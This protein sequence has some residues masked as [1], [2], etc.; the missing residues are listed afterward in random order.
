M[1]A[2]IFTVIGRFTAGTGFSTFLGFCALC[3]AALWSVVLALSLW[4]GGAALGR[5]REGGGVAELRRGR[6]AAAAVAS[7]A[8]R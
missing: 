4:V 5:F 8:I 3:N 7:G 2:G 1:C 6:D